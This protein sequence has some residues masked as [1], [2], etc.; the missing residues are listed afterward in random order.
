LTNYAQ[1]E[2][3]NLSPRERLRSAVRK[4]AICTMSLA[5]SG[6]GGTRWVRFLL[7]HHVFDDE[8][9]TFDHQLR[10]LR[11]FGEFATVDDAVAT[12]ARPTGPD[13]RYFCVTFDDGFKCC[14]TNAMPI[15]MERGVPATFFLATDYIGLDLER[16][17]ATLSRFYQCSGYCLPIEFLS[18]DDC[19]K[20]KAAGMSFGSHTCSHA[21][22]SHLPPACVRA[23]LLNCK[24]KIERELN[25]TCRHF[26][27]PW[28]KPERDFHPFRHPSLA[29]ELGYSTFFTGVRGPNVVGATLVALHRDAVLAG[30]NDLM[31]KYF[32]LR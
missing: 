11:N 3:F 2:R 26:A 30:D 22:L 20:M 31:L 29:S 13:G 12:L 27:A 15:L 16:D 17:W 21:R 25:A 28:G 4:C 10:W 19:R 8:R 7:Y 14:L 1:L 32:L 9:R 18:W 5:M 23:E 6:D 24:R